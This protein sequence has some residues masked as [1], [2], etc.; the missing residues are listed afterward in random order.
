M[1]EGQ[2][3]IKYEKDSVEEALLRAEIERREYQLVV[4]GA[5]DDYRELMA[6]KI[7]LMDKTVDVL[8]DILENDCVQAA[9][10]TGYI[11]EMQIQARSITDG[12]EVVDI[13]F[14]TAFIRGTVKTE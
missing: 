4:I 11:G 3:I 14:G 8:K 9:D 13:V 1:E 5:E 12:S 6:D 2:G 10:L 7:K